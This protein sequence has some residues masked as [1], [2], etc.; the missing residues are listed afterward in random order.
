M[1]N[2][3]L[4]N[5]E[6]S[7]WISIPVMAFPD[8][9]M[10]YHSARKFQAYRKSNRWRSSSYRAYPQMLRA[11][12][13]LLTATSVGFLAFFWAIMIVKLGCVIGKHKNKVCQSAFPLFCC[14]EKSMNA[15]LKGPSSTSTTVLPTSHN[16]N[17]K[18]ENPD[19][20]DWL[21][22]GAVNKEWASRGLFVIYGLNQYPQT[23]F[24][25]SQGSQRQLSLV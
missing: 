15:N 14:H 16:V 9:Q 5:D 4:C 21:N 24:R 19:F 17:Q 6:N 13:A 8:L 23:S 12:S 25:G 22:Q 20:I 3:W 2:P 11:D 7:N 18:L 1:S 10:H